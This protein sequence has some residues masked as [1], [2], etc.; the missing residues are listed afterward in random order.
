MRT[1]TRLD[2]VY[3][4]KS[5]DPQEEAGQVANVKLMLRK[6][7][8]HIPDSEWFYDTGSRRKA[9]KRKD[10][11]RLL[12]L[13]KQGK[14]GTVYVERQNRFGTKNGRELFHFLHTIKEAG[15][16]LFDLAGNR[17]LTSDEL[18]DG[19]VTYVTSLKSDLE[20]KELSYNSLRSRVNK[21]K[22]DDS[23]PGGVQPFGYDKACYNPDK[24]L[25][26]VW[27]PT[28]SQ[29][30]GQLYYP[31][32]AGSLKPG[33]DEM[34]IPRK[35][36]KQIMKLRPSLDASRIRTVTDIYD[37]YAN[38]LTKR[39]VAARLNAEGRS[40]Y[41][42]TFNHTNVGY[43]LANPAYQG[44]TYFGKMKTGELNG[45]N[46]EGVIEEVKDFT[47][48]EK[49]DLADCLVRKDT[50][51]GIIPRPLFAKVQGRLAREQRT[52]FPGRNPEYWLKPLL[53]CGHCGGNMTGR[54]YK[55]P[56]TKEKIV[57][58]CCL[59]YVMGQGSG[60]KTGCG[61][62]AIRHDEAE[63][64]LLDKLAELGVAFDQ[65]GTE[66]ARLRLEERH[67]LLG[68]EARELAA[69]RL[70]LASEGIEA[71]AEEVRR[72]LPDV[73]T[74]IVQ[75][76]TATLA[77]AKAL[78]IQAD[79]SA[80]AFPL[81][82]TLDALRQSVGTVEDTVCATAKAKAEELTREHKALT[83]A[84]AKASEASQAVLK[85]ELDR[86]EA[87]IRHYQAEA[88]PLWDRLAKVDE[89]LQQRLADMNA[90]AADWP[91]MEGRAK[92]EALLSV[93]RRVTLKWVREWHPANNP[94]RKGVKPG[95]GKEGRFSYTLDTNAIQWEYT[96]S[97]VDGTCS[98]TVH[99]RNLFQLLFA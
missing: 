13:I 83:L 64:L 31:D 94:R 33:P 62:H 47:G 15:S 81:E 76:V 24:T 90:L 89:A 48:A 19:V 49:R 21:F 1:V 28:I 50:H 70:Q 51:V 74:S 75:S 85:E 93:F 23:W 16:R 84:W 60:V 59:S 9:D 2:V 56:R 29:G 36:K 53:K 10:F 6:L 22:E 66:Q 12:G 30:I 86:L 82:Y 14:I 55:N 96:V 3:I 5:S 37:W 79:G 27:H 44:D 25:L 40:H 34:K 43:I 91:L 8:R 73:D 35:E 80:K 32:Q 67:K 17:D 95:H 98:S 54:S 52:N 61:Y 77:K 38:G 88:V 46:E 87:S 71:Y 63:R 72:R 18:G 69:K 41:G 11:Q 92:A 20:L 42:G 57:S 78:V 58:Y 45:F 65:A 4:R 26:W 68:E 7:G 97:N 99:I 39:Q